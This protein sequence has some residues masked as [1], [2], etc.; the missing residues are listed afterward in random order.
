M[1]IRKLFD[2]QPP[3]RTFAYSICKEIQQVGGPKL[4]LK[5]AFL[6]NIASQGKFITDGK[7]MV[8]REALTDKGLKSYLGRPLERALKNHFENYGGPSE[9]SCR[10]IFDNN[11]AWDPVSLALERIDFNPEL[12][13]VK[14]RLTFDPEF[15]CGF[16]RLRE[17]YGTIFFDG[18]KLGYLLGSLKDKF[19]TLHWGYANEFS[20]GPLIVTN[21]QN[22]KTAILMPCW[23]DSEWRKEKDLE[24]AI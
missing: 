13:E 3:L 23:E 8:L 20:I 7:V 21:K 9:E 18:F 10:E 24:V 12:E 4:I 16:N 22:E 2:L 17:K 1:S 14:F 11:S 5:K 6:G 15:P 19:S